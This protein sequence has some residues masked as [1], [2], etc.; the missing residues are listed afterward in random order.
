VGRWKTPRPDCFTP[1][2]KTRHPL[3][4]R[5]GV[6]CLLETVNSKSA[7]MLELKHLFNFKLFFSPMPPHVPYGLHGLPSRLWPKVGTPMRRSFVVP[8]RLMVIYEYEVPGGV[9]NLSSTELP[10]S[11]SPWESSPSRKNSHGNRE[12]KP[13]P[14]NQ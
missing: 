2:K 11:W 12:S 13:G 5:L 8:M 1:E 10:R 14:H 9:L 7:D 6:R 3:Y 4:S